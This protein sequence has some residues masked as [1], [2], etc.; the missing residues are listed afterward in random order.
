MFLYVSPCVGISHTHKISVCVSIRNCPLALRGQFTLSSARL[1]SSR[2]SVWFFSTWN[3]Q[4]RPCLQVCHARSTTT[5]ISLG[6]SLFAVHGALFQIS[7]SYSVFLFCQ[8]LLPIPSSSTLILLWSLLRYLIEL[9]VF[10]YILD[11][12][13]FLGYGLQISSL[14]L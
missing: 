14:G 3:C 8:P 13:L 5:G 12:K 7:V 6:F 2:G 4:A 1:R 10:S 9:W 11:T